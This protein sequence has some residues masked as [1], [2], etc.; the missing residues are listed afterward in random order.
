M[1]GYLSECDGL[2]AW[3]AC[4]DNQNCVKTQARVNLAQC[5]WQLRGWCWGSEATWRQRR[6]NFFQ[7]HESQ[8]AGEVIRCVE[9]AG[10]VMPHIIS[11]SKHGPTRRRQWAGESCLLRSGASSSNF[12]VW[13]RDLQNTDTTPHTR[14]FANNLAG[15]SLS[16]G[17]PASSGQLLI[18]SRTT[19]DQIAVATEAVGGHSLSV[20]IAL[21]TSHTTPEP[22][23]MLAHFIRIHIICGWFAIGN[24]P[25]PWKWTDLVCEVNN[26]YV[27]DIPPDTLPNAMIMAQFLRSGNNISTLSL[28]T[29]GVCFTEDVEVFTLSSLTTL[30]ITFGSLSI[31]Q[32]LGKASAPKLDHVTFSQIDSG[33]WQIALDSL[34]FL[35]LKSLETLIIPANTIYYRIFPYTLIAD[36]TKQ[37]FMPRSGATR[38][39]CHAPAVA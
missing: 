31:I 9:P 32:L 39:R 14:L 15:G 21:T 7:A 5:Q 28:N 23:A 25:F 8:K 19:T 1:V 37:Y 24:L 17:A 2:P 20:R 29:S 26:L 12:I 16:L 11:W 35:P 6:Q 30:I 33:H 22:D 27:S 3:Q 36:V 10:A 38:T 4:N 18:N 13:Q 34:L